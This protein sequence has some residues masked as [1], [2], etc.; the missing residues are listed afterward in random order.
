VSD[1]VLNAEQ[2]FLDQNGDPLSGGR[3]YFYAVDTDTLVPTWKD[4]QQSVANTNPV[5]L[6]QA[7]RATIWGVGRYRQVV[8]DQFG[9]V[10]WDKVTEAGVDFSDVVGPVNVNGAF[11]V[12]GLST[13]NGDTVTNGNATVNGSETVQSLRVTADATVVGNLSAANISTGTVTAASETING[14][15]TV[16]GDATVSGNITAGSQTVTG[17]FGVNNLNVTNDLGVGHNVTINNDLGVGD[18][19]TTNELSVNDTAG[20]ATANITTLNVGSGGITNTG[21]TTLADATVNNLTVNGNED[22]H[23]ATHL[24]GNAQIDGNLTVTGTI[25]GGGGGG[26]VAPE[27]PVNVV[28]LFEMVPGTAPSPAPPPASPVSTSVTFPG[29]GYYLFWEPFDPSMN[30]GS[31][32][33]NSFSITFNLP[34]TPAVGFTIEYRIGNPAAASGTFVLTAFFVPVSGFVNASPI[35]RTSDTWNTG[36]PTPVSN[37]EAYG[38]SGKLVHLGGNVWRL[39]AHAPAV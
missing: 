34:D 18:R 21:P 13:F 28:S 32:H 33:Y 20:I 30:V 31:G 24:F 3:V 11:T 4:S 10:Q 23:G 5:V 7:G 26:G 29:N 17:T 15:L 38:T 37:N 2:T 36:G 22:V 16:N 14:P 12:N 35:Y 25:T 6:D 9:T 27:F 8:T 1:L 19:V 39:M